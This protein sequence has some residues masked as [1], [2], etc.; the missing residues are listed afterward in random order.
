MA[1]IV[2]YAYCDRAPLRAM[3]D[4]EKLPSQLQAFLSEG[5][6]CTTDLLNEKKIFASECRRASR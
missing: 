5:L 3:C 4:V 6:R 1:E 2:A